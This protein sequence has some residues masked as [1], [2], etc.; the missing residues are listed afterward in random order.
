LLFQTLD[1]LTHILVLIIKQDQMF[2]LET[3]I[4]YLCL[5]KY[6]RKL[7]NSD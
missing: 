4:V 3:G 5:V 1:E 7:K 2:D 6:S